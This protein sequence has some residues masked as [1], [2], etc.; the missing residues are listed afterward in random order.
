M[1]RTTNRD[2]KMDLLN[3]GKTVETLVQLSTVLKHVKNK[4]KL[5]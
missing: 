1:Y 5:N 2:G 3:H 4:S